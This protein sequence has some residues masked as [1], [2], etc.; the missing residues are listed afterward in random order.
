LQGKWT[1]RAET[2]LSG[3]R[4]RTPPSNKSRAASKR[5]GVAHSAVFVFCTLQKSWK[6]APGKQ[7]SPRPIRDHTQKVSCYTK[8]GIYP[9]HVKASHSGGLCFTPRKLLILN[10]GQRR[11]RTAD[12][13]LFRAGF[14]SSNA[15]FRPHSRF[16]APCRAIQSD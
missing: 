3:V 7:G 9:K 4:I 13:G 2:F 1:V 14:V 11:D 5:A 10:G 15:T 6:I 8:Q 12:A 16:V